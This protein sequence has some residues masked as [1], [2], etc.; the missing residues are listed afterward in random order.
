MRPN[1]TKLTQVELGAYRSQA[2]GRSPAL[3]GSKSKDV[4]M[5]AHVGEFLESG[6]A[7]TFFDMAACISK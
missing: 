7:P 3:V 2:G 1:D 6:T 4:G 5:R